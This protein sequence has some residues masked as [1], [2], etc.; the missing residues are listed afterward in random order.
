[1]GTLGTSYE[2][3]HTFYCSRPHYVAIK[4]PPSS[5]VVPGYLDSWG[6]MYANLAKYYIVRSL[7]VLLLLFRCVGLPTFSCPQSD[8]PLTLK[9]PPIHWRQ[10]G[11]SARLM[12]HPYLPYRTFYK[13]DEDLMFFRPCIT[14]QLYINY[15][16]DAQI[17]I[18]SYTITFL[19]MFRATNAHFQEVTLYTCSI[20]YRHSLRAVVVADR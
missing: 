4:A 9:Q 19:Y 18:Y 13:S 15:Q 20:W 12:S 10:A 11:R 14:F 7:N 17:I 5:E 1:M 16:P 2:N 6:N 8:R 3:L